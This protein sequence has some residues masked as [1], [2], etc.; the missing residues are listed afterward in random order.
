MSINVHLL[1]LEDYINVA[2][3]DDFEFISIS[4]LVWNC[5]L[6]QYTHL[7]V[8]ALF[9]SPFINISS[10]LYD[11]KEKMLDTKTS[12]QNSQL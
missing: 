9:A 8:N 4:S 1:F 5:R 12:Q 7:M 3:T 10:K 2:P 6:A 11:L